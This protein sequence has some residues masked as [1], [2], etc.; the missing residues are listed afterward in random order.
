M[1]CVVDRSP[2]DG[3]KLFMREDVFRLVVVPGELVMHPISD[4][5]SCVRRHLL[6]LDVYPHHFEGELPPVCRLVLSI[7]SYSEFCGM[8]T[9][10]I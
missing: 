3:V 6:S 9:N 7:R 2:V 8:V 5:A 1:E 4:A 10:A